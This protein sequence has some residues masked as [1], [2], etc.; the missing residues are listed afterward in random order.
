MYVYIYIYIYI[1][2]VRTLGSR[3]SQLNMVWD[4][5]PPKIHGTP[6]VKW[7][8]GMKPQYAK[9]HRIPYTYG[10]GSKPCTPGE[11]PISM[12]IIVFIGMFTYPILMVIGINPYTYLLNL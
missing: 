4:S 3:I 1:N 9:C 5:H 2:K 7:M 8:M 11:H 10:Y 12:N 6:A